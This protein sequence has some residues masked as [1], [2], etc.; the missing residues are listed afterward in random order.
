MFRSSFFWVMFFLSVVSFSSV[1][2]QSP[3]KPEQE[4]VFQLQEMTIDAERATYQNMISR[5][6]DEI[7]KETIELKPGKDPVDLLRSM[8]SS[9]SGSHSLLG[10]ILTPELRGFDGKHTKVLL[11]GCPINTPWN[12]TSSLSGF[13]L[14]R[15]QKISVA[16]GG[17]ALIYGSNTVAGAVNLVLP[18][19][20]DLEGLTLKQEVGGMGTRHQE[21]IYGRVA[22]QNEH[23]FALFQDDYDGTRTYKTYGTG[24][25]RSDNR[26]FM[27]R[28]RVETDKGWIMKATLLESRGSISIPNYK[29][30]FEPWEMSHH[31]FVIEKNFGND[32]NLSLRYAKYRDFSRTQ[33]YFDY[34]LSVAS[35]TAN[36]AEDV[37]INMKTME[38]LYNFKAGEKHLLTLGG[39]K[40]E[41]KDVGH[42]VKASINNQWLDSTGFFI[43]DAI[44]AT[45]KWN[46]QLVARSDE[47][48]NSDR[49]SSWSI[50]SD[51]QLNDQFKF[52]F[53]LSKTIRFPNIQELYRGSKVFGNET[54]E[55]EESDNLE[56]RL[57]YQ[58][59]NNWEVNLSRFTS[60]MKNKISQTIT[61][62]GG[63]IPGVGTLKANDAYY[64]NIDEAQIDGWE[65]GLNG[66]IRS[67]LDAWLSYTR[68]DRA[69]DEKNNLR[70]VAKPGY[71]LTG[72]LNFHNR[73]TSVMLSC[74]R[75]GKTPA[76]VTLDTAG[77]ATAYPEVEA[78]T[79]FDLG[80]RQQFTN[81]FAF[82]MNI[83]NIADDDNIVL[84]QGSDTK[85][86]A[87][88]LMDPIYYRNGR[89]TT[90]GV[91][92]KF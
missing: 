52:G 34:N 84:I 41:V 68:I 64:I 54:L 46:L 69:E 19:A 85:N 27:Y 33:Y 29:E 16:P 8:N 72:G 75:Q 48:Y 81:D 13:P 58:I 23:L 30:R 3:E 26:M 37:T 43:S 28:G 67:N 92:V 77:K 51:Y 57:G 2:A 60:E 82:Y 36:P 53:G 40:Q 55:P 76:T 88:L 87:G 38:I 31:D 11:D 59:N 79:C 91:E 9:I 71:R 90:A 4:K 50:D 15:L 56:F 73:K 5:P 65:F 14:R 74:E 61:A 18:T 25:T 49:H 62:A 80:F 32:Q 22:H 39:Q 86:K 70:L 66:Q 89:R 24:E 83:E 1:Y 17:S 7:S 21:F 44:A 47:S 78:S 45:E 20:K 35:G 10:A 42:T 63:V 12:N 6:Q